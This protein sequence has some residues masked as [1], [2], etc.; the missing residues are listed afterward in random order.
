[1]PASIEAL[2]ELCQQL[3]IECEKLPHPPL[4]TAQCADDIALHRPGVRLKNLFLRDNYGRRHFL[5][6]TSHDALVDLKALSKTQQVSRLGFASDE[7]L[8]K[9]LGVKK[10]CVSMLAL[11]NDPQC[12]VELWLDRAIWNET[13][14]ST[15][16]H[17]HPFDN[18]QTWLVPK[19]ALEQLFAHWGHEPLIFAHWGHEPLII[20]VPKRCGTTIKA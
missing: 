10:G 2:D 13:Q 7:R 17:C 15:P 4:A 1:M 18:T 3:A 5:L 11:M 6:I 20:D 16:Y 9:F 14:Q 19:K 12:H 8:E